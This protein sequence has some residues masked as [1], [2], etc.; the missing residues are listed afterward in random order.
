M[1]PELARQIEEILVAKGVEKMPADAVRRASE[2]IMSKAPKNP[3]DAVF[4]IVLDVLAHVLPVKD[5][6]TYAYLL[7]RT[8]EHWRHEHEA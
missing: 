3:E 5:A 2:V 4:E 1:N 8:V 7:G 6:V